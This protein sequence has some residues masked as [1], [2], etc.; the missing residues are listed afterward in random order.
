MLGGFHSRLAPIVGQPYYVLDHASQHDAVYWEQ[1]SKRSPPILRA[2][3]PSH[4][5]DFNRVA[6]HFHGAFKSRI[7]DCAKHWDVRG[8][9]LHWDGNLQALAASCVPRDKMLQDAEGLPALWRIVATSEQ[10]GG[11]AG[12]WPPR[13]YR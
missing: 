10:Q 11:V 7:R 3:Q 13:K 1:L 8:T 6:E 9:L 2:P 5:P 12:G 4:G